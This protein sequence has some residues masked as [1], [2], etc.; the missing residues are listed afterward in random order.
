MSWIYQNSIQEQ[1]P[2]EY[3]GFVYLITNTAYNRFYIGKKNY[4]RIKKLPPL[5]GRKNKRHKREETDWRD[6]WG[7][8]T[9]L[10][11]DL[12]QLGTEHFRREILIQCKTK[13]DMSYHETRMQFQQGVLLDD[14]YY[15]DFIGCRITARGLTT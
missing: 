6:Y 9:A 15:N 13:T 7:S 12:E 8:S 11:K 3:Q 2:E 14:S 5:K 4:W 1:T 10:L